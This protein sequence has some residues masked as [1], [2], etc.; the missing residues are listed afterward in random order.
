[1]QGAEVHARRVGAAAQG[2][3][4]GQWK[5]P[6]AKEAVTES[7]A[8]RKEGHVASPLGKT[9]RAGGGRV[10]IKKT[11]RLPQCFAVFLATH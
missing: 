9:V 8:G 4:A 10:A 5:K 6:A 11:H 2:E 3:D 1:M 7:G